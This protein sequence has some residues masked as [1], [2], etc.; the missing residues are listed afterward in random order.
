MGIVARV[1]V[2]LF[3]F[4]YGYLWREVIYTQDKLDRS[5]RLLGSGLLE[6]KHLSGGQ[7]GNKI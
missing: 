6:L 3:L 2:I 7:Y 1:L 4:C 5:V